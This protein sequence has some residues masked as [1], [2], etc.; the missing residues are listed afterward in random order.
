MTRAR[1]E[2]SHDYQS[3]QYGQSQSSIS[4]QAARRNSYSVGKRAATTY[5]ELVSAEMREGCNMEVAARR[6]MQQHGSTALGNRMYKSEDIAA[7]FQRLV[8]RIECEDG[9]DTTE[10]T[11]RARLE[12]PL[13]YR[14]MNTV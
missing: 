3:F 14:A 1:T 6:V 5:E 7:R 9:C 13:L 10:A 11:R 2:F 8:K 4:A 12:N